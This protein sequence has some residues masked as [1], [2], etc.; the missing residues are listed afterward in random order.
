[1]E[2][3]LKGGVVVLITTLLIGF[4]M[5]SLF[6]SV[7][8]GVLLCGLVTGYTSRGDVEGVVINVMLIVVLCGFLFWPSLPFMVG[9]MVVSCSVGAVGGLIGYKFN[10][11]FVS[12]VP[13]PAG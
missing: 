4:W 12:S 7:L 2:R 13:Q 3:G 10:P 11:Y 5:N 8:I 1:M 6:F 9:V